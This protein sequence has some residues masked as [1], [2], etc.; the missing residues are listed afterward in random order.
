MCT[1]GVGVRRDV[2]WLIEF[3]AFKYSSRNYK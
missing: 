2:D 3:I 1:G